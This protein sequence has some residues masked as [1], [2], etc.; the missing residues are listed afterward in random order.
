MCL[1]CEAI[2][3]FDHDRIG[4][5]TAPPTVLPPPPLALD[6][7]R[8]DAGDAEVGDSD[9]PIDPDAELAD[10]ATDAQTDA[11]GDAGV[12]PVVV[13]DAGSN[14]D[15][16]GI[17]T[18]LDAGADASLDLDAGMDGGSAMDAAALDAGMD[19]AE[20]DAGAS[21]AALGADADAADLDA[22]DAD[23][24]ASDAADAT[25]ADG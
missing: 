10:A 19:A 9:A 8:G 24:D 1:G 22:S 7:S 20:L 3:T 18:T 5:M 21:D 12:P 14:E 6:A 25:D 11:T 2:A 23:L 16:S 15:A 4:T 13:V 17:M